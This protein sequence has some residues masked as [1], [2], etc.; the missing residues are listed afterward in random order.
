MFCKKEKPIDFN[1]SYKLPEGWEALTEK[2]KKEFDDRL[3]Q[4]SVVKERI[5]GK[6]ILQ[7]IKERTAPYLK[8]EILEPFDLSLDWNL[9]L[10]N[11]NEILEKQN[12]ENQK[13]IRGLSDEIKKLKILVQAP[14]QQIEQLEN[15]IR[16]ANEKVQKSEKDV[17][18]IQNRFKEFLA[19]EFKLNPTL[20]QKD[21]D[22]LLELVKEKKK[23]IP[24][25]EIDED[26]NTTIETQV[27]NLSFDDSDSNFLSYVKSER[28]FCGQEKHYGS[29]GCR[30]HKLEAKRNCERLRIGMRAAWKVVF[31][32]FTESLQ[33]HSN[34]S[35]EK[36]AIPSNFPI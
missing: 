15:Q 3:R 14:A 30:S 6:M 33:K 23:F 10:K 26:V 21:I 9:R 7:R 25:A 18:Q 22:F 16:E 28:C 34:I 17:Q 8:E 29:L 11:K 13:T 19:I 35:T 2:Q 27:P 20:K 31:R 36:E 1:Q 12:Q 5:K 4:A 24:L 32:G